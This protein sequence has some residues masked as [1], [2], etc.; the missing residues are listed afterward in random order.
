MQNNTMC[1]CFF[2]QE[3][4]LEERGKQL[5]PP[6]QTH[7]LTGLHP[8]TEYTIEITCKPVGG[9]YYSDSTSDM[10]ITNEAGKMPN[11]SIT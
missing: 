4:V 9:R 7:T 6:P 5:P 1:V 2:S 8:A 10:A 11:T 3:I